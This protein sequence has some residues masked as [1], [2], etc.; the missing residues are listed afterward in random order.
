MASDALECYKTITGMKQYRRRFPSISI[1][2]DDF[3]RKAYRGGWVYVSPEHQGE[4][5]K[6]VTVYDVNSMFPAQMYNQMLP[7]GKPFYREKP[8]KGELYIVRFKAMFELKEGKL[9]MYQRKGSFRTTQSEYVTKSDGVE[10]VTLT[11]MDY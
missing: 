8:Q 9:P 3:L 1:E 4:D 10:E 7:W 11:C 5:L 2:M 6:D